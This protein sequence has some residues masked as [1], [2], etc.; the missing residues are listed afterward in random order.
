MVVK[1]KKKP[2]VM[3]FTIDTGDLKSFNDP[4]LPTKKVRDG[5]LVPT[6]KA[7]RAKSSTT[8]A[9]KK[10]TKSKM[11]DE[12]L[13][14]Q[15]LDPDDLAD[16]EDFSDDDDGLTSTRPPKV[17]KKKK[18]PSTALAVVAPQERNKI[19]KI[20]KRKVKSIVGDDA[21]RML[22]MLE[23]DNSLD[24]AMKLI[25]RRLLQTMI[26]M[27]PQLETSMRDSNG[28]YGAHALN[29]SIQTIRE[30]IIDL[31]AAADR[32]AIG[33]AIVEKVIRPAVLEVATKIVEEYATVL[34]EVKDSIEPEAYAK[35]RQAQID[36]RNRVAATLNSKY[37]TM[38]SDTIS[39][40]QR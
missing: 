33:E 2:E 16:S 26:D 17:V 6:K 11:F 36:S 23:D 32:G 31:E 18:R 15:G 4:S 28:R 40:L 5:K 10:K 37:E 22:T 8:K 34:S 3:S 25:K 30:L 19:S 12:E 24:A 14:A 35:V 27:I 39:F 13:A 7:E 21:D 20:D 9:N 1:K 29:G 38:K